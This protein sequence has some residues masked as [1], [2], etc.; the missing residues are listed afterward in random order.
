MTRVG[1]SRGAA[2]RAGATVAGISETR[3][4]REE[5]KRRGERP[6]CGENDEP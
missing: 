6:F 3:R 2:E 5:T 1:W 4:H